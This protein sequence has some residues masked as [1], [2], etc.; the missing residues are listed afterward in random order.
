MQYFPFDEDATWQKSEVRESRRFLPGEGL[1][2]QLDGAARP[3]VSINAKFEKPH[4]DLHI[5][6]SCNQSYSYG[7]SL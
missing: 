4:P 6:R 1:I 3:P 5:D 7:E 2:V